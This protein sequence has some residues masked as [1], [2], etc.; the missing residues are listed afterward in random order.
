MVS[1]LC[2]C[3][4]M[5]LVILWKVGIMKLVKNFDSMVFLMVSLGMLVSELLRLL[6]MMFSCECSW[7]IC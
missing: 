3:V 6:V 2:I 1:V 4:C 5:F 7:F